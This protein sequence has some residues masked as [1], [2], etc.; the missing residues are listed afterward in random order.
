MSKYKCIIVD[1]E[2]LAR[3]VIEDYISEFADLELRASL[4]SGLEAKQYLDENSVDI[5]FLDINM[6][7]LSGIE[8]VRNFDI[9]ALVIFT[10]A[11][12]E[13]AVEA[14][15][16][17]GFDYLVKPISFDRFLKSIE[18][19]K[20]HLKAKPLANEENEFLIIKENKRLYKV[21]QKDILYL[22]AY[23]DYVKVITTDKNYITKDKLSSLSNHVYNSIIQCHRSYYINID[24]VEYLE[25]NH[26]MIAGDLISISNS[27]KEKVVNNFKNRK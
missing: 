14:F 6:P 10:T 9:N 8:L 24:Q 17:S 25:G 5:I 23:G 11:Y 16:Y 4:K 2:P 19:A 26:A 3:K 27:Y 15:E 1:D 21:A 12:P 18:K 13:Y 22:E 20:T 7:R